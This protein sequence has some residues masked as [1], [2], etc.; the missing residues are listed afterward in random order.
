MAKRAVPDIMYERCSH[1]DMGS[2]FIEIVADLIFY[3]AC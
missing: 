3:A 1:C 2:I